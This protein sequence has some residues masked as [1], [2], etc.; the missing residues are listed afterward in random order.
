MA[1]RLGPEAGQGKEEETKAAS[2]KTG[3]GENI[4]NQMS[5]FKRWKE[6]KIFNN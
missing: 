2:T 3:A 1:F 6:Y 5:T 4:I